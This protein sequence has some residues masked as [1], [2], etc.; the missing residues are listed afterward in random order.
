MFEKLNT[1]QHNA[2]QRDENIIP[3]SN[4]KRTRAT[5]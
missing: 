3:K 2:S 1:F 5:K 4:K